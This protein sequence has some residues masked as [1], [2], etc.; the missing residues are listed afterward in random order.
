MICFLPSLVRKDG[1][2]SAS[3]GDVVDHIQYAGEKIGYAH[4]GI[5]SDFDGMLEGPEG[6]DDVRDYPGLVAGLLRKGVSE[7]DV[8]RVCGGNLVRVMR[9]VERFAIDMVGKETDIL[10][11]E[12]EEVWTRDQRDM[13]ATRGAKRTLMLDPSDDA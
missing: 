11:D 12:I 13:I 9:E 8:G 3:V 10:C 6:L 7:E 4:V 1:L 2:K 5:G